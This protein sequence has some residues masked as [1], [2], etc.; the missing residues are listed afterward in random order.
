VEQIAKAFRVALFDRRTAASVSFN[1]DATGDAVLIV[2]GVYAALKIVGFVR[3]GSFDIFEL[4]QSMVLGVAG[5]IFLSFAVWLMGTRLIKGSGEAQTVIRLIGFAHFPLLLTALGSDVIGLVGLVWYLSA[6]AVV[7]SGG[8]GLKLKES[9][10]SV[11][12]GA[13]LVFLIQS[14]LQVPFLFF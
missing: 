1:N 3:G 5:W 8:L 4:L 11:V 2:A 6:V 7:T 9:V 12:L 14:L 13:A 10:A